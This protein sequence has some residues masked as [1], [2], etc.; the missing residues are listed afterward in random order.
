MFQKLPRTAVVS[1]AATV[2]RDWLD[3]N[4]HMNVAYYVMAFDL[5]ID[6]FKE[7]IGIYDPAPLRGWH[8]G[9]PPE[10]RS[11]PWPWRHLV[12]IDRYHYHPS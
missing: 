6:A 3:Y 11:R 10:L 12:P 7:V 8:G 1:Y 2:Q 5:A 9:G 4:E